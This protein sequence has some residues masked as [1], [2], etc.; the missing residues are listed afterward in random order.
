MMELIPYE[1][2]AMKEAA[3]EKIKLFG[4]QNRI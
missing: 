3:A 1:I 4:A 2:A